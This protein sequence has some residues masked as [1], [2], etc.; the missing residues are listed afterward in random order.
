MPCPAVWG[1]CN[2][3]IYKVIML[4]YTFITGDDLYI[5]D[6][7]EIVFAVENI[8]NLASIYPRFK[9]NEMAGAFLKARVSNN[10]NKTDD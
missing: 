3:S 4:C 9:G 10:K 5:Y 7:L 1:F 2:S 8:V 6:Q